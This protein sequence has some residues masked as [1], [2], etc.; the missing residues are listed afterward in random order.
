MASIVSMITV[1]LVVMF[2]SRVAV[3]GGWDDMLAVGQ[4]CTRCLRFISCSPENLAAICVLISHEHLMQG[5]SFI[6]AMCSQFNKKI[7]I[8][9]FI[10][11]RRPFEAFDAL[12]MAFPTRNCGFSHNRRSAPISF[13]ASS[14]PVGV[15]FFLFFFSN[16]H[17]QFRNRS[18]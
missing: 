13:T 2:F 6:F 8:S 11:Y 18:S 15:I 5:T 7:I 16:Q 9:L 17:F 3:V 4:F 1:K 10:N 12:L 14:A